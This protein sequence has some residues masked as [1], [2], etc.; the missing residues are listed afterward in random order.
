MSGKCVEECV[1]F[2]YDREHL[3]LLFLLGDQVYH[4]VTFHL[5]VHG[6]LRI[7]IFLLFSIFKDIFLLF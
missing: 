3:N 7:C 1:L 6:A 2:F 4:M 5:Y